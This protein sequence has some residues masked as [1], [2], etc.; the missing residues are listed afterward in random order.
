MHADVFFD[1]YFNFL[2]VKTE[3]NKKTIKD[4]I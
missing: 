4:L 3:I 2:S 1:L